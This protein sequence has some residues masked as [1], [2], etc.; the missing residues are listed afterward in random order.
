[1]YLFWNENSS[2]KAQLIKTD[3]T[4]SSATPN[5]DKLKVIGSYPIVQYNNNEYIVTDNNNIYSG[6]TGNL[7]YNGNDN[8]SKVQKERIINSVRNNNIKTDFNLDINE[9]LNKKKDS[10]CSN[11]K[12]YNIDEIL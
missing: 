5:I 11:D 4:K 2:G 10:E 9:E 1:M 8:S 6:S 7:V 12:M 3:G